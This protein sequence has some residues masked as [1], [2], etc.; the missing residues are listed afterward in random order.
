M[1]MD[2]REFTKAALSFAIQ[3]LDHPV[4]LIGGA[5]CV[6]KSFFALELRDYLLRHLGRSVSVLDLDCY[7]FELRHRE[8][9][10]MVVTGYD[11]AGYDLR[12]AI[13]D[14]RALLQGRPVEVSPYNK[15][16]SSRA[17]MTLL[18]PAEILL[19]EGAM[20]LR[21]PVLRFKSFGVYMDAPVKVLRANRVARELALG[22][23]MTRIEAKF[24]RLSADYTR[25]I[26][27]QRDK[28]EAILCVGTNYE[29]GQL[30]V[31]ARRQALT[32][33]NEAATIERKSTQW[34]ATHTAAARPIARIACIEDHPG[35]LGECR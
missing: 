2:L 5:G 32:E 18:E 16:T 26:L 30:R 13:D 22:F 28:A 23:D 4:L 25:F 10:S 7:L 34:L 19:V 3:G 14:I 29:I 9:E 31:R 35:K 8:S 1:T 6:G 21:E 11:P 33:I 15:A 17:P 20:A 12:H 24:A 27:P